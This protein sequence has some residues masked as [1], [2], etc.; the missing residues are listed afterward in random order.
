MHESHSWPRARACALFPLGAVGA[1][2]HGMLFA[3]YDLDN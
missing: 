2:G 3:I 1:N